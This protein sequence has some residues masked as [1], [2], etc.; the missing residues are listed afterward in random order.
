MEVKFPNTLKPKGRFQYCEMWS[1]HREFAKIVETAKP[2]SNKEKPMVQFR[3][4]LT[5][6]RPLLNK[7]NKDKFADL[8]S[9]QERARV[10]LTGIQQQL[11][12][13]PENAI[14]I[15][16]EKQIRDKYIGILSSS[17]ALIKQQ[18]KMEWLHYGVE[19]TRLFFA[20]TKQRKLATYI[21]IIKGGNNN[22]VEG[23]MYNY[24]KE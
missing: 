15:Q 22:T 18:H 21:Y 16:E 1:K 20:K 24:Y 17:K 11:Q 4:F 10:E 7:I 8:R 9:Q 5:N 14:L 13:D 23:F 12:L 2:S 3:R 19:N 6:M